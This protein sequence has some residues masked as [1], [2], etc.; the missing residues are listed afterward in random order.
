MP[1]ATASGSEAPLDHAAARDIA[2]SLAG[3]LGRRSNLIAALRLPV[4][5]LLAWALISAVAAPAAWPF[6][7]VAAGGVAFAALTLTHGVVEEQRALARRRARYHADGIERQRGDGAGGGHDG[8]ALAG[9]DHP[10]AGDLDLVG[11]HGLFPRLD[12]AATAHGRRRLASWLLDDAWPGDERAA[13]VR[14]LAARH[15]W[16]AELFASGE[17]HDAGEAEAALDRWFAAGPRRAS[18]VVRLTI[19]AIRLGALAAIA[20]AGWAGGPGVAILALIGAALAL[21]PID[22]IARRRIGEL[23]DV[24]RLRAALAA[25]ASGLAHLA[26]LD[27]PALI[28]DAADGA[29]A[30]GAL[31]GIVESL[32]KRRNPLWA[33]GVGAVLLAEWRARA[34]LQAWHAAHGARRAGWVAL[35]ADADALS[36]LATWAAEQGGAWPVVDDAGPTL[37]F[38]ALAHPLLPRTIRVGNDLAFAHGAT[39]IVTGANAS[40]KSTFLRTCALAVVLARAGTTVPATACRVRRVRLAT[41]MRVQDDFAAG[42]SR[43]QAEVHALRRVFDRIALPGP[44]VL[45]LLD[46]ILGGTNSHERHIGTAAVLEAVRR[47]AAGVL[48]STHDV[49]LCRLAELDPAS[50]RLGHFADQAEDGGGDLVF[51]YRLRPGVV[52]STNALAVMRA[53]GLPVDPPARA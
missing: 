37:E 47:R 29:A 7:A 25:Q 48:I 28:R 8:V 36:C 49:E 24:D 12:T 45:V 4:F 27:D 19:G 14:A 53:A 43:F 52:R 33:H 3:R 31:A 26:R 6:V 42:R 5:G 41:V 35:I 46:E 9:G 10:Y 30:T 32:T 39:L 11:A 2:E 15:A 44:P 40:G 23:V 18:F 13:A 1:P 22:L 51:D 38:T 50:V 17:D 20:V 16:R 34:R 21:A